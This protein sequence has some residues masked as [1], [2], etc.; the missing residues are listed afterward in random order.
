MRDSNGC[1]I[2]VVK[3]G[4]YIWDVDT[5]RGIGFLVVLCW[6]GDEGVCAGQDPV[7]QLDQALVLVIGSEAVC[8]AVWGCWRVPE[9]PAGME[10]RLRTV[11]VDSSREGE[12]AQ[13]QAGMV[14]WECRAHLAGYQ[15]PRLD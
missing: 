5:R 9:F 14:D 13:Q 8:Y 7:T 12:T 3:V 4:F 1:P 11:G 15:M 10:A 2:R 6:I